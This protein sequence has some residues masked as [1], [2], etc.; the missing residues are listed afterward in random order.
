MADGN[1]RSFGLLLQDLEGGKVLADLSDKQSELSR[2]LLRHAESLGRANGEIS[3]KLK[4]SADT[5]TVH[6]TAE[7]A[8]KEPKPVRQAETFWFRKDGTLSNEDP[9]QTKLPLREVPP[10]PP[11]RDAAEPP[12]QPQNA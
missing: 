4:F 7:I 5:K 3:L 6:V 1:M 11:V 8:M 12:A 10:A 2:K 9:R